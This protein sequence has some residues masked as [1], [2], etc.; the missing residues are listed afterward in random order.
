M[1]KSCM[2]ALFVLT[3]ATSV[4]AADKSPKDEGAST[5]LAQADAAPAT[6]KDKVICKK[7][8]VTGSLARANRVCMTKKQWE[9]LYDATRKKVDDFQSNGTMRRD[10]QTNGNGN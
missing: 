9:D 1:K 10:G 2:I 6:D 5:E 7:E 3:A 4:Q 8:R